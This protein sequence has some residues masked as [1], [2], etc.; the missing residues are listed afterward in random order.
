MRHSFSGLLVRYVEINSLTS[1]AANE[2]TESPE[3][4]DISQ[5]SADVIDEANP[6]QA[7]NNS[8][9]DSEDDLKTARDELHINLWELGGERFLDIGVLINS[10][11]KINSVHIDLPWEVK[12]GDVS[13]IGGL[14]NSEKAVAAVFNEIVEY[15]S[16]ADEAYAS[17]KFRANGRRDKR[18]GFRLARLNSNHFSLKLN[19]LP[20]KSIATKLEIK[21]PVFPG[22]YSD[23]VYIRFRIRSIPESVYCSTFPQADKNLLSSRTTTR[24]IDFRINTRRGVPD[25]V[26]SNPP[27]IR[28]PDFS[29]IHFFL[30]VHR[31]EICEF[32]GNA[33][34]AC[35]SLIDE[36]EWNQ[37][38][39]AS[40]GENGC[41]M[42]HS[43]KNYLGYQWTAKVNKGAQEISVKDLGVLGRFSRHTTNTRQILRF[44]S[45][46][47][48][49]GAIGSAT[50]DIIKPAV[51]SATKNATFLSRLEL[52]GPLIEYLA[53][54][55]VISIFLIISTE[56]YR[57]ALFAAKRFLK[58]MLF[59][60]R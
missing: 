55:F 29:K 2:N 44:V 53:I 27:G 51:P 13:D 4:L 54:L 50:W 16:C 17:I 47:F 6:A 30:T 32:Y 20:D 45:L 24:I 39:N 15:Q 23:V 9:A 8:K 31:T 26:L 35:R 59:S 7:A 48:I 34:V 5:S 52:R 36:R 42:N 46:L 22:K 57:H 41:E 60:Q 3:P 49:F 12:E 43:V 21:F 37:Y 56:R 40:T 28:F 10:P 1:N 14:L 19:L 25:E 18:K 38:V 33:F 11:E 58:D